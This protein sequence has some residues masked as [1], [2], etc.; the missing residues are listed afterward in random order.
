[1]ALIQGAQLQTVQFQCEPRSNFLQRRA[2]SIL[3]E[4]VAM[5]TEEYKVTLIV[6]GDH[7][8]APK[9]WDLR[10]EGGQHSADAAAKLCVEVIHDE[11]RVGFAWGCTVIRNFLSQLDP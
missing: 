11:L 9:V 6:H 2:T 8:P 4:L 1:M 7:A 10:E 5:V 3:V